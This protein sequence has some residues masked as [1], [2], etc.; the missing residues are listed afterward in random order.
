MLSTKQ[1]QQFIERYKGKYWDTSEALPVIPKGQ[2]AI[3]QEEWKTFLRELL[4]T[5]ASQTYKHRARGKESNLEK[6]FNSLRLNYWPVLITNKT[7][8]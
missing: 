2:E 7:K 3:E 5:K 4:G 1:Q 6:A 8:W